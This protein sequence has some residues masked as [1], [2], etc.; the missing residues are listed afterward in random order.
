MKFGTP[1]D[2]YLRNGN[3]NLMLK[4]LRKGDI[5]GS[6]SWSHCCYLHTHNLYVAWVIHA[7]SYNNIHSVKGFLAIEYFEMILKSDEDN[8]SAKTLI[9]KYNVNEQTGDLWDTVIN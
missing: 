4:C 8:I 1:N 2:G 6:I 9:N 7:Y 3:K 5:A